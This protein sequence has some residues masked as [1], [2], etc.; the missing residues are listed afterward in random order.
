MKP[1][2]GPFYQNN[3]RPNLASLALPSSQP[4]L[5]PK[6]MVREEIIILGTQNNPLINE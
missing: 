5:P 4:S 2:I 1:G 3:L 6:I